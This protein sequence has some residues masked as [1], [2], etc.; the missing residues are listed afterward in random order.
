MDGKCSLC[1]GPLPHRDRHVCNVCLQKIQDDKEKRYKRGK[2]A[3]QLAKFVDW[4]SE[5]DYLRG[6]FWPQ[7]QIKK[8]VDEYLEQKENE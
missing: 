5:E 4:L 1:D 8:V 7:K 3:G 6:G 2:L